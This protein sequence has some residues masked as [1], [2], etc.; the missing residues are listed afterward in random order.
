MDLTQIEVLFH[1]GQDF[2]FEGQSLVITALG[3]ELPPSDAEYVLL[4]MDWSFLNY[5]K[6]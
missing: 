1:V 6:E 3:E 4:W 5:Q 2:T